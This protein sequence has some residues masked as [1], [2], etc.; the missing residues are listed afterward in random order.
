MWFADL[1][2]FEDLLP[3]LGQYHT[4]AYPLLFLG[5]FFETL[6]PF[7]L[8]IYGEFFFLPGQY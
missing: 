6:I 3:I 2:S 8:V 1:K 4:F 5:A 7:S